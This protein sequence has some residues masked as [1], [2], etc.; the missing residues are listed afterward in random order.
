[1]K[2][3]KRSLFGLTLLSLCAIGADRPRRLPPVLP[4]A[5]V[6][7]PLDATP[8]VTRDFERVLRQ[9]LDELDRQSI[10][11][12]VEPPAAT[13]PRADSGEPADASMR[14]LQNVLRPQT[15]L[16]SDRFT[17]ALDR[18]LAPQ[19]ESQP[20]MAIRRLPTTET[21]LPQLPAD[22]LGSDTAVSNAT[23]TTQ[24]LIDVD[25]PH[26]EPAPIVLHDPGLD[27]SPMPLDPDACYHDSGREAWVYDA[28]HDVP[29]Q[30]PWVEWGR[31]WYGDGITPRGRDLF[32]PMNLVRP[33][34]YVYGDF[35][36]G[37]QA[38][39]NAGGRAD[40]WANRLNLDMDLQITDTERFHAF[41]GPLDKQNRFTRWEV[42]DG[43]LRYRN[44]MNLT[45]A[46][47]FFEGDLG[48]MLGALGNQS[49]PFELPISAG[50]MPLLFQNGIWMEDA[51]SGIAF[52]LPAKHSRL[53]NWANFD[54]SFFAVFD[55]LNSPAFADNSDAQ[56][57]GTAWFIEAYGGYIETGYAYLNHRNDDSLSYH[58]ATFSFTR[59]YFDRISN[60]V[61]VIV[62][63]GQDRAKADRTADG[64]LLLVENSWITAAPL[65]VVPYANFFYGWDRPQSVA[66]AGISGGIL[67]NTGIN[68][69]TDG[70]N[71]FATLDTSAADTAGGSVGVDL[72]GDDLDRQLLLELSYLTPHGDRAIA[73]GDQYAI[74]A[75]YQFPIS[76]ATLLRFDVMHGWREG[77]DDVYGTRME[78]RWKF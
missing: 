69:D 9:T 66:R 17:A 63:A 19:L 51:V 20:E 54:V 16:Q 37:I 49:S 15:G 34:F 52:A 73:R 76:N 61:R 40:N 7:A 28:K 68:F 1:M 31:I 60:S 10:Q 67:R 35:R 78:F 25:R 27:F 57:F 72:I 56:A 55:Q 50:L 5:N 74:G 77:D 45:P 22:L 64:G 12:A 23:P 4:P 3:S 71:G 36:T 30:H 58:N 59:R 41:V 75:R 38:G 24:P 2:S 46:T 18:Y 32:G 33:K 62:N 43:D 29:T 48:V 13:D 6:A 44:E 65:T 11:S 70:L 39:R 8:L 53:L 42:I 21:Q 26:I 47:A 14:R